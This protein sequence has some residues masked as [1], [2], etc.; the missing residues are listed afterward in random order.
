MK[1]SLGAKRDKKLSIQ[2]LFE[3]LQTLQNSKR[4]RRNLERKD[5][6]YDIK[7]SPHHH[8]DEVSECLH[9]EFRER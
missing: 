6:Y 9:K 4:R 2:I 1:L 5:V 7:S 3:L 8:S